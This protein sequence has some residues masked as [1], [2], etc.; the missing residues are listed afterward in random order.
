[1][2]FTIDQNERQLFDLKFLISLLD[3]YYP[4]LITQIDRDPD[5]PTYG[6]CDRHY[7]MYRLSDFDSGV[8]QQSSLT[9]AAL[10]R[11]SDHADL[12]SCKDLSEKARAY[13]REL[14][15]AINRR[16]LRL[17]GRNGFFDEYYPGERSFPATVFAAYATLKSA[18]LLDQSEIIASD[19]LKL[20]AER[21]I[22]RRASPAANQDAACAAF[23]ALFSKVRNW[24]PDD[25]R[26]TVKNLLLGP[27][28]KGNFGEYGGLDLG[29]ATVSLNYLAYMAEDDSF[30]ADAAL[31]GLAAKIADFITPMGRLGGEFAARS[32]TYF[33]P[34]GLV[35]AGLRKS[36]VF[37]HIA[38]LDLARA[39]DKLDDRY[40]THYCLPSLA[41]AA[42]KLARDGGGKQIPRDKPGGWTIHDHSAVGLIVCRTPE[43]SVCI[44]INKGGAFQV[45]TLGRTI[46]DCGYR[47]T[48]NGK[49]YAS[50]IIDDNPD[51]QVTS[52]Q[53][54][55]SVQIRAPFQR[56]G[57]LVATPLKMVALRVLGFM[58]PS[59]NAYFKSRLIKSTVILPQATLTRHITID[60]GSAT[61]SVRD[62][63]TGLGVGD[64]LRVAP[65][66][67]FR[68]V[69]SAKF[70][71]NGEAAYFEDPD[72]RA[73]TS[74]RDFSKV[75]DLNAG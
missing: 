23:L 44:G 32:T 14:A 16:N 28:G 33:L 71:Q 35:S 58:G 21:L 29:Y 25:V 42:F 10:D 70:Y 63:I 27:D 15:L 26:A 18:V 67:S 68:L 74:K 56:Y 50:C 20:T 4:R 64:E 30:P 62:Q 43:T 2:N 7:W 3:R 46:I 51:A 38:G 49:A 47:V 17:L 57:Q 73:A 34:F 41:M 53:Q 19:A 54:E 48:N 36:D 31:D 24:K 11:L 75:I 61:M 8:L 45:E 12:T 5:S 22:S 65:P 6:S 39:F 69:P 13:W 37:D 9:L 52:N 40:L 60:L 72:R 1:M 55:L 59:L 66:W